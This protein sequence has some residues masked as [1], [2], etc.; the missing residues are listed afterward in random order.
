MLTE[1]KN[2]VHK[3]SEKFSQDRKYLKVQNR[4]HEAKNTIIEL[5]NSLE[6]FNIRLDQTEERIN[7]LKGLS[8]GIS[9]RSKKK[10][11]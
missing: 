4:N 11:E 10:T 8:L 5:K 2:I 6:D 9:Q 7:K 3:Q 1:I